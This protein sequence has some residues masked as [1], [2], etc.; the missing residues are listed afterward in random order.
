MSSPFPTTLVACFH[1]H[2][3]PHL[4]Q[5][6]NS[7]VADPPRHRFHRLREGY[8]G[9]ITAQIGVN[10]FHETRTDQRFDVPDGVFGGSAPDDTRIAPA[11]DLPR[12][13]VPR[14]QPQPF[15]PR[16]REYRGFLAGVFCSVSLPWECLRFGRAG[17]GTFAGVVLPPIRPA[18][19]RRHTPRSAGRSR[20]PHWLLAGWPS[21]SKRRAE[22]RP[23]VRVCRRGRRIGNRTLPSLWCVAPPKASR[24]LGTG[25][26]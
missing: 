17:V 9:E 5:P 21:S 22:G 8:T 19:S 1:W 23:S 7:P 3:E 2:T 14:P 13:S 10:H 11:P 16:D 20:H 12:R 4:D 15:A 6:K 18:T 24:P 26:E 25:R